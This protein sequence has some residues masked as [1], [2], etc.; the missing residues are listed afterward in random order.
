MVNDHTSSES[1]PNDIEKQYKQDFKLFTT[2]NGRINRV[3]KQV[4]EQANIH[5]KLNELEQSL[6]TTLD[7][8]MLDM[9]TARCIAKR[10]CHSMHMNAI[11]PLTT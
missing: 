10:T 1:M 6:C 11:L 5:T 2:I 3:V 7:A 4:S 8:T 9:V